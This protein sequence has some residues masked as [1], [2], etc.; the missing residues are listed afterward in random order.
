MGYVWCEICVGYVWCEIRQQSSEEP[1]D[2]TSFGKKV[3]KPTAIGKLP[4]SLYDQSW[5][6]KSMGRIHDLGCSNLPVTSGSS[7]RIIC[8]LKRLGD[9]YKLTSTSH[10]C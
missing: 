9:P 6:V 8:M 5:L 4:T 2:E 10:C 3:P 1:C 7:T